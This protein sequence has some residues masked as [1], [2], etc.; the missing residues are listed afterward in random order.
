[1]CERPRLPGSNAD[2]TLEL[3]ESD[4]GGNRDKKSDRCRHKCFRDTPHDEGVLIR[5]PG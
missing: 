2:R 1:M 3:I 5:I 4:D